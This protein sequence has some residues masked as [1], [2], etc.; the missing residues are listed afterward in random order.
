[1]ETASGDVTGQLVGCA[2]FLQAVFLWST[3][4]HLFGAHVPH[5]LARVG[6]A[7][8]RWCGQ[9]SVKETPSCAAVTEAQRPA[10]DTAKPGVFPLKSQWVGLAQG[11]ASAPASES[12]EHQHSAPTVCRAGD[13]PQVQA[14]AFPS[15]RSLRTSMPTRG[16]P[17]GAPATYVVLI[18]YGLPCEVQHGPW[19]YPLPEEVSNLEVGRQCELGIFILRETQVS[20]HFSGTAF[21]LSLTLTC[22]SPLTPHSR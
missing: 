13:V 18:L 2:C 17:R 21:C 4:F 3:A 5:R 19:D 10:A 8:D 22:P 6:S 9:S 14:W 12:P 11:A 20:A 7:D 16:S 1:M 15:R